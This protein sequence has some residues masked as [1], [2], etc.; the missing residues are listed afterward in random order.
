MTSR[1]R[2]S[3]YVAGAVGGEAE[4]RRGARDGRESDPRRC[5]WSMCAGLDQPLPRLLTATP[6]PTAMQNVAV[7]QETA[8]SE[9]MPWICVGADHRGR[10]CRAV[11]EA[12]PFPAAPQAARKYDRPQ[13]ECGAHARKRTAPAYASESLRLVQGGLLFNRRRWPSSSA[14]PTIRASIRCRDAVLGQPP[15]PSL[16]APV[17][18]AARGAPGAQRTPTGRDCDDSSRNPS[19]NLGSRRRPGGHYARYRQRPQSCCAGGWIRR[20]D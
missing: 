9:L 19:H 2:R 17:L 3:E 20:T 10:A 15:C 14:G 5:V 4:R 18:G 1:S 13:C 11:V 12:V 8:E 16:P 6:F 7:G